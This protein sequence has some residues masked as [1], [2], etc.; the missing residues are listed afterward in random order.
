MSLDVL[1]ADAVFVESSVVG[2]ASA[3]AGFVSSTAFASDGIGT[4]GST[5]DPDRDVA[6]ALGFEGA[7]IL[8]RVRPP[9]SELVATSDCGGIAGGGSF[10]TECDEFGKA[11]LGGSVFATV[12]PSNAGGFGAEGVLVFFV[13][14]SGGGAMG[15]DCATTTAFACLSIGR[16]SFTFGSWMDETR[17]WS[18]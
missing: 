4:L 14:L 5:N 13:D 12:S 10:G 16:K 9:D 1:D 18:R 6:T 15:G 3:L 7:G 2:I 11:T 17:N 8:G